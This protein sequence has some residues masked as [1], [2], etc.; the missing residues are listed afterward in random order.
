MDNKYYFRKNLISTCAMLF[1][2]VIFIILSIRLGYYWNAI[3]DSIPAWYGIPLIALALFAPVVSLAL[4]GS[5][6]GRRPWIRALLALPALIYFFSAVVELGKITPFKENL[7]DFDA[8][9]NN[10]QYLPF[11]IPLCLFAFYLVFVIAIPGY[12]VTRIV[13]V[14]AMVAIIIG[15]GLNAVVIV[16]E[17]LMAVL[18]STFGMGRFILNLGCMGLDIAIFFIML[19]IIM[20]Y[21][22]L[23]REIRQGL[24]ESDSDREMDDDEMDGADE[25]DEAGD[26][27]IN[28]GGL[29][30]TKVSGRRTSDAAGNSSAQEARRAGRREVTGREE[31]TQSVADQRED[32]QMARRSGQVAA[33]DKDTEMSASK[34]DRAR[35]AADTRSRVQAGGGSSGRDQGVASGTVRNSDVQVA[36]DTRSRVQAGGASAGENANANGQTEIDSK[37]KPEDGTAVA[38]RK[39][40]SRMSKK[41]IG[42]AGG[43]NPGGGTDKP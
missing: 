19:S 5:M 25:D 6:P 11:I 37:A 34:D 18:G 3:A 40:R 1:F 28:K 13:G 7:G 38:R 16:Y 29:A 20:S 41:P 24:I 12:L 4:L 8:L 23:Q 14:I 35:A 31:Q 26:A 33:S 10:I 43:N 36:A 22:A 39:S 17:Q 21:C 30:N 2:A 32:A 42:R 9:L 27:P 15:Y